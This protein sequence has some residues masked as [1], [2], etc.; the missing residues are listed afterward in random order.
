IIRKDKFS[1]NIEFKSEHF[2]DPVF[3]IKEMKTRGCQILDVNRDA[4]VFSYTFDC[5]PIV[6]DA[7]TLTQKNQKFINAKGIY[8]ILNDNFN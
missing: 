5:N 4:D 3:L 7:Y 1:L 8:W 2:I 6:K